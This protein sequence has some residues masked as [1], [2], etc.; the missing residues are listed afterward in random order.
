MIAQFTKKLLTLA[1]VTAFI[2]A[3]ALQAR[4]VTFIN[5]NNV[6]VTILTA[7]YE[8]PIGHLAINPAFN[9]ENKFIFERVPDDKQITVTIG[10]GKDENNAA[11]IENFDA[12]NEDIEI[13]L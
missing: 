3:A 13:E 11:R 4:T 8:G 10:L 2:S 5:N 12:S 7:E 9:D 6:D 1:F